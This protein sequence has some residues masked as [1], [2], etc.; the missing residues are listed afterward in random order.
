MD[1]TVRA[2]IRPGMTV[3]IVTKQH[4]SSG[5]L[6]TGVVKDILTPSRTHPRGIKVRLQDGQIG[7]VMEIVPEGS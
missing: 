7:R 4:Q 1:G 6:T 5:R 2:S 3:R